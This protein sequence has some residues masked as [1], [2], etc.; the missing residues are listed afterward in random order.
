MAVKTG[1]PKTKRGRKPA[2]A[3]VSKPVRSRPLLDAE[4]L[5]AEEKALAAKGYKIVP[6]TLRNRGEDPGK[7]PK[8][9]HKR[10]IEIVCA[11]RGCSARRRVA[12]SDLHQV[13]FCE[14]HTEEAR[15]ERK[16]AARRKSKP[17]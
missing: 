13:R 10:T 12:T 1:T 9:A 2:K 4:G 8:W 5:K 15:A 7:N 14:K 11:K 17:R 16:N 6:G 3:K